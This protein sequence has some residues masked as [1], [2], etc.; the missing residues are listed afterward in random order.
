MRRKRSDVRRGVLG[1][2]LQ[3]FNQNQSRVKKKK[4][5][6]HPTKCIT[7]VFSKERREDL[8]GQ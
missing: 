8:R 1:K 3:I 5:G 6:Q 4:E 7:A 2:Q